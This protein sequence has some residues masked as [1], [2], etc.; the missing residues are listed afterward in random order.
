[1]QPPCSFCK[2]NRAWSNSQSK[3]PQS[4]NL[5]LAQQYLQRTMSSLP[6]PMNLAT[7]NDGALSLMGHTVRRDPATEKA[8]VLDV[9]QII[10]GHP[11]A[12]LSKTFARI[13]A[14][15]PEF[16]AKCL[17]LKINGRGRETPVADAAT[18]L[19]IIWLCPG[20]TAQVR[21]RS[22]RTF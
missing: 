5:S 13:L 18:L 8:S 2:S 16:Q 14:A 17:K 20:K 11:Q 3:L 6:M 4:A 21:M 9:I 22:L 1:M 7:D 10:T 19:E 15:H 12:E